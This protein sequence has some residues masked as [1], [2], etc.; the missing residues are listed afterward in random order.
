MAQIERRREQQALAE[1]ERVIGPLAQH[2]QWDG[3]AQRVAHERELAPAASREHVVDHLGQVQLR[4]LV[5]GEIPVIEFHA[6]PDWGSSI[7]GICSIGIG[8]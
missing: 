2:H 3:A 4:L 5:D 1:L 8:V 7:I 6:L